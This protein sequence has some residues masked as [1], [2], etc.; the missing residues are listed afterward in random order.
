MRSVSARHDLPPLQRRQRSAEEAGV[1]AE[2]A[3]KIGRGAGGVLR[4]FVDD[5]RFLQGEGAVEQLRL[6]DAEL[7]GIEPGKAADRGN[8]TIQHGVGSIV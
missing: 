3:H 6:D 4:D 2:A 8:L 5:P 7:L 1:E